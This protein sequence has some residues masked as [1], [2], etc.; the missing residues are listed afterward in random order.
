MDQSIAQLEFINAQM[1]ETRLALHDA[2]TNADYDAY[3]AARHEQRKRGSVSRLG[4]TKAAS[5]SKP[6]APVP[7]PAD[8]PKRTETN[9]STQPRAT[10]PTKQP[11]QKQQQESGAGSKTAPSKTSTTKEASGST[12]D[13]TE[14]TPLA[15]KTS[16]PRTT[17]AVQPKVDEEAPDLGAA[18]ATFSAGHVDTSFFDD[19]S[20][21]DGAVGG[22]VADDDSDDDQRP[23]VMIM[24][25]EEPEF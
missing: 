20:D 23:N 24:Q 21:D 16:A 5:V 7:K 17:L 4:L 12:D 3:V 10:P 6:D 18:I 15:R 22:A 13:D 2:A 1:A 14:P 25:D 19:V 8:A 9:P 11:Q